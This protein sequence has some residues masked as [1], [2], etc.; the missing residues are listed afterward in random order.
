MYYN[1]QDNSMC[2]NPSEKKSLENDKSTMD[3]YF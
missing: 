2:Q 3:T 1:W